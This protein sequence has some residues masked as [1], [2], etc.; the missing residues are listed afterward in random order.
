MTN[1]DACAGSPWLAVAR[2]CRRRRRSPVLLLRPRDGV[3]EPAP[4]DAAIVLQ[5]AELDRARDFRHGAARALRRGTL[6]SRSALLVL[7]R[8]RARR[9]RCAGASGGPVLVAAAR[10]RRRSRWRSALA[11]LPLA[12]GHAASAR[13]TSASS[14]QSWAG[15]A[16]DVAKSTAIGAVF[17]G[18]GAA[19]AIGAHAPLPA[20]AGGCPASA[21]SSAS[22]AACIYAGPG[23]ARPALQPLRRRCREGARARDVLALAARGGRRVGEVYEVDASRRTTGAN[24]YVTGLGRDE[25]RRPL[26]QPAR[27]LRAATRSRLVVAHELGHVHYHDV[28]RGLLYLAARRA[29]RRCSPPSRLTRRLAPPDEPRRRARRRCRRW[30]CRSRSSR[31]GVTVVANQL[32]R[33]VEARADS[34]ALRADRRARAV[35]RLRARH[36]AAQRR[37]T[38]T[39]RLARRAARHPP[40]DASSGSGSAW[41]SRRA[42]SGTSARRWA[43]AARRTPGGS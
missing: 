42:L 34:Y 15:W 28:P 17:A 43:P 6:R 35:H 22:R 23:R 2:R 27:G 29:G 24:A 14:T 30:R 1:V 12:R 21:S 9:A 13:S 3:I 10:R 33:R 25:A 16:G 40:A 7:A 4:V 20:R 5:P 11:P 39:R 41:R 37:P 32:S 31:F 19:A 26:R 18:V 36:R 8:A 38:P